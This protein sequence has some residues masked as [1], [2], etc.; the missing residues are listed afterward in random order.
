MAERT[1]TNLLQRAGPIEILAE[2][3]VRHFSF[4]GTRGRELEFRSVNRFGIGEDSRAFDRILQF[5]DISRP[6][7]TSQRCGSASGKLQVW[8]AKFATETFQEV[9]GKHQ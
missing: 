5:A 7:V 1:R 6:G 3:P 4:R 2:H 9:V 8:L